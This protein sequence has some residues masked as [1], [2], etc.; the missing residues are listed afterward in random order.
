MLIQLRHDNRWS[1]AYMAAVLGV[2]IARLISSG[3][4]W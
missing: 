4:Y 2:L 3:V 1:E